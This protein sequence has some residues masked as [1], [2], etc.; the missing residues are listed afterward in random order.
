MREVAA[1]H[2]LNDAP[3]AFGDGERVTVVGHLEA[4]AISEFV[5]EFVD[6]FGE[7]RLAVVCDPTPE[8]ASSEAR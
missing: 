8:L 5:G 2:P 1:H 6:L 7:E 4:S 3:M